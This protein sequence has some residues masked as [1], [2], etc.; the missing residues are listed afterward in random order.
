MALHPVTRSDLIA[1]ARKYRLLSELRREQELWA[2]SD[3]H[4][5]V[6]RLAREFPGA[7]RELDLLSLVEIEARLEALE[8]AVRSGRVAK[9]MLWMHAYHEGMRAALHVRRRLAGRVRLARSV[10]A[11]L[12]AEAA[13]E[14][15]FG[16]DPEFVIDVAALPGGE[17]HL[18]VIQRLARN[19][20][21]PEGAVRRTLFPE[22]AP[23]DGW[24]R[25]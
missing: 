5:P 3:L 17:L 15:G 13:R 14:S 10:A 16:C 8:H 2:A 9:W 24:A 21:A 11:E 18:A 1:L 23:H 4:V 7:L 6:V 19:L 25:L 22:P 20:V 12:A